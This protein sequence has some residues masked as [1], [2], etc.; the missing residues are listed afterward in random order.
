MN[1]SEYM[2]EMVS[3]DP[4]L[5][6]MKRWQTQCLLEPW[7]KDFYLGFGTAQERKEMK[8]QLAQEEKKMPVSVSFVDC[9]SPF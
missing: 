5:P 1:Y 4:D 2:N 6:A 9:D 8:K 3:L 7:N